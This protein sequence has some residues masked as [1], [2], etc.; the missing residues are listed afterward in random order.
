[1][2]VMYGTRHKTNFRTY[3]IYCTNRTH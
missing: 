3:D 1:M 2:N